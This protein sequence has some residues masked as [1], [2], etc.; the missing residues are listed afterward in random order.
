MLELFPDCRAIVAADY[1][2]RIE[3]VNSRFCEAFELT[4]DEAL[5]RTLQLFDG[6]E[7]VAQEGKEGTGPFQQLVHMVQRRESG[8]VRVVCRTD[9]TNRWTTVDIT[10]T[11]LTNE[12]LQS[13]RYAILGMTVSV[14]A[15]SISDASGGTGSGDHGSASSC[16]GT[17]RLGALSWGEYQAL[18]GSLARVQEWREHN[19]RSSD[20]VQVLPDQDM[21]Q[22]QDGGFSGGSGEDNCVCCACGRPDPEFNS[23]AVLPDVPSAPVCSKWCERIYLQVHGCVVEVGGCV[24]EDGKFEPADQEDLPCALSRVEEDEGDDDEGDEHEGT[25]LTRAQSQQATVTASSAAAPSAHGQQATGTPGP[26]IA[27][28]VHLAGVASPRPETAKAQ[29]PAAG[30]SGVQRE[31]GNPNHPRGKGTY[32]CMFCS[33]GTPTTRTAKSLRHRNC[34]W[35]YWWLRSRIRGKVSGRRRRKGKSSG[36]PVPLTLA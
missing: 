13:G 8:S 24:E 5:E 22:Q 14:P 4:S 2:H 26:A 35:P 32:K 3:T 10:T 17:A 23:A 29:A 9:K 28:G 12:T 31:W 7:A 18:A 1:A 20:K 30:A 6:G 11:P 36:V 34:K 15:T 33:K 25:L 16:S 27:G 21:H 19:R